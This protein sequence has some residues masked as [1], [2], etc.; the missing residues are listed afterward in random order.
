MEDSFS[1]PN[2]SNSANNNQATDQSGEVP[3]AAR[4]SSRKRKRSTNIGDTLP[5]GIK[6]VLRC[7]D[8]LQPNEDDEITIA[9]S[10]KAGVVVRRDIPIC[11]TNWRKVPDTY[12]K[13]VAKCLGDYFE[14]DYQESLDTEYTRKKLNN[15][16]RSYKQELYR[17]HVK[18]KNPRIVRENPPSTYTQPLEEWK[19]FVDNCNT[20]EFK[21]CYLLYRPCCFGKS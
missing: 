6:L 13:N 19:I 16:W 7:N 8:D 14:Y 2:G 17:D 1:T 11:Y 5:T 21:R 3:I 20:Q 10:T 18:D 4:N 15:M 12:K 9:F